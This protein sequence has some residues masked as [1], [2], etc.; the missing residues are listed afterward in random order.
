MKRSTLGA[1]VVIL[2]LAGLGALIFLS[3]NKPASNNTSSNGATAV[4]TYDSSGFSPALTTVKSGDKV[5]FKNNSNEGIQVDSNPH[6]IHTD[7]TDLNVGA[8][9][10]GASATVTVNKKG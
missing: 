3:P 10:P 8:I 1:V 5:T 4:I 7:D 9:A 2:V 6:P